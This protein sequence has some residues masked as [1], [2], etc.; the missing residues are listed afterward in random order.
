MLSIGLGKLLPIGAK[1]VR[2]S[3]RAPPT[4]LTMCFWLV[5]YTSIGRENAH[6][7]WRQRQRQR[8]LRRRRRRPKRPLGLAR[9]TLGQ[10]CAGHSECAPFPVRRLSAPVVVELVVV[11]V[12]VIDSGRLRVVAQ[13]ALRLPRT[14]RRNAGARIR[15]RGNARNV[16]RH[17]RVRRVADAAP[18]VLR[19][20]RRRPVVGRRIG[21][22]SSGRFCGLRRATSGAR[23]RPPGALFELGADSARQ[24]IGLSA[25][26][27][28]QT[29]YSVLRGTLDAAAAAGRRTSDTRIG[30]IGA[31]GAPGVGWDAER[32]RA[33]ARARERERG[34]EGRGVG[35]KLS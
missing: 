31:F 30:A 6:D 13:S 19:R 3:S 25:A 20:T 14:G 4:E 28:A 12:V 26:D 22:R 16:D 27:V 23:L 8:R 35:D 5:D 10:S 2:Q 11:V 32:V 9:A 21:S 29:W 1:R 34:R 15:V 18:I 33:R 24:A 17:R 7:P